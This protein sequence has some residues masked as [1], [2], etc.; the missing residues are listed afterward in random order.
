MQHYNIS[1]LQ[2]I[3]ISAV[4]YMVKVNSLGEEYLGGFFYFGIKAGNLKFLRIGDKN[5]RAEI[6]GTGASGA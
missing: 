1:S 6:T 3:F 2:D 4:I 5:G